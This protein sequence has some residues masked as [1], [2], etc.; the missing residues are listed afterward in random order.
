MVLRMCLAWNVSTV[1][2]KTKINGNE[3][4]RKNEWIVTPVQIEPKTWKLVRFCAY[5]GQRLAVTGRY[6]PNPIETYFGNSTKRT[7]YSL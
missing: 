7:S 1:A 6:Y 2:V 4:I 3:N 5:C